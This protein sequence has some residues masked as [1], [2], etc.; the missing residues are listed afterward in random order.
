MSKKSILSL[1][2]AFVIALVITVV[3]RWIIP[4]G[5][6]S[7]GKGHTDRNELSMPEIPLIVKEAKERN[8]DQILISSKDIKKEERIVQASLSWKKWPQEAMQSDFIAKDERGRPINDKAAYENALK[9]WAAGDIP[10]GVP[11]V[12]RML[13]NEDPVKK[14]QEETKKKTEEQRK[15]EAASEKISFIRK[16]MRA[17]TFSIDQ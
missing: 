1:I 11:V 2:I 9:M 15:K 10:A 8:W 13:T 12:L 14:R 6:A 16:G 3:V 4:V 5:N 7:A 17:V